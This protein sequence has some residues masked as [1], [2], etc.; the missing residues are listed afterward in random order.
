MEES[1]VVEVVVAVGLS[2]ALIES[3][4]CVW[5]TKFRPCAVGKKCINQFRARRSNE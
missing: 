4:C 2:Q 5:W 3:P 1:L